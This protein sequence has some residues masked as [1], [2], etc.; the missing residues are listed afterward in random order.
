MGA[1]VVGG[2]LSS[3]AAGEEVPVVVALVIG[4]LSLASAALASVPILRRAPR[5]LIVNVPRPAHQGR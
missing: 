2:F 1:G 4:G 3:A 5:P